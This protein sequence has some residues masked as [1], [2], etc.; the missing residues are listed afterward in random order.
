[1]EC[2]V[3]D[4]PEPAPAQRGAVDRYQWRQGRGTEA[5]TGSSVSVEG[6]G[7]PGPDSLG[8]VED[9]E[10]TGRNRTTTQDSANVTGDGLTGADIGA[11]QQSR[12]LIGTDEG[13]CSLEESRWNYK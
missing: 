9:S 5:W 11:G 7:R 3:G 10:R 8:P 1:M 2:R 13:T 12:K 6:A 4:R